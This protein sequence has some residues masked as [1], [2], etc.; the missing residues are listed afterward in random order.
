MLMRRGA[1]WANDFKKQL[2][3]DMDDDD[4]ELR[5]HMQASQPSPVSGPETRSVF[6]TSQPFMSFVQK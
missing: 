3:G 1:S 2:M 5:A 6:A 4:G